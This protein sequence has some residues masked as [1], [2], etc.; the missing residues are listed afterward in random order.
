[1]STWLEKVVS[2]YVDDQTSNSKISDEGRQLLKDRILEQITK[3]I[4][5][6]RQKELEAEAAKYIEQKEK[7]EHWKTV[8]SL[9]YE[10][11]LLA[12]LVGF[13]VNFFT[14]CLNTIRLEQK[15]PFSSPCLWGLGVSCIAFIF[16]A[17]KYIKELRTGMK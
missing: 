10:S 9:I 5:A 17:Y 16:F 1:M 12:I 4:L 15:F 2:F 13:A 14:E 8:K 3:D 7:D 6:E 11:G